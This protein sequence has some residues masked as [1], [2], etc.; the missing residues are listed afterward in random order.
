MQTPARA[1]LLLMTLGCVI[2]CTGIN[3]ATGLEALRDPLTA[4][5]E[6]VV[7]RDWDKTTSSTRD[8]LAT[9]DAALGN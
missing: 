4:L 7:A 3:D 2:G 5:T 1:T 8:V 9:W 6:G